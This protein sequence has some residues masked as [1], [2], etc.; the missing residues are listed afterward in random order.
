MKWF[1]VPYENDF[2]TVR[3]VLFF[4]LGEIL[5]MLKKKNRLE[6]L[7]FLKNLFIMTLR[8]YQCSNDQSFHIGVVSVT[9]MTPS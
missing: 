4:I 8:I 6:K 9:F 2:Y 7:V 5:E 3:V 1:S